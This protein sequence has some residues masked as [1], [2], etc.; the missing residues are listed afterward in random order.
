MNIVE[1]LK[2]DH[3][4]VDELFRRFQIAE[5][6]ES[7]DEIAKDIVHELSVHAAVE[8]QFVYPLVRARLDE[9]GDLAD[10]SIEEHA[11]VKELL[12]EIERLKAGSEE[13]T[14]TMMKVIESV[15]HHVAEE[16]N[17]IL[18]KLQAKCDADTLEKVGGV[19]DKAK[20]VVPTHPHPLV[21]GT[22]AA[23]LVAGPWAAI[24]DKTRD[25]VSG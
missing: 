25:L 3:R 8:E 6:P 11:E 14:E 1:L 15:R 2:K 9:D 24:I 13:H 17:E 23:Q 10:H 19:V 18:P 12:T 22:A 16:E 7:L 5:V 20:S 21:P 4:E